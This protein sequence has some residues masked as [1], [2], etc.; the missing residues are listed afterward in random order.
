MIESSFS[1]TIEEREGLVRFTGVHPVLQLPL[2]SNLKTENGYWL[3]CEVP[4]LGISVNEKEAAKHP[5][6]KEIM[7]TLGTFAHDGAVL[8][9]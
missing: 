8:D 1:R 4:G 9:W 2:E 5:F 6:E 3:P 7:Q